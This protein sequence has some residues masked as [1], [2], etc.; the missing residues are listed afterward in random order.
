MRCLL[1]QDS[2]PP[3]V[4][5]AVLMSIRGTP[6]V[7]E[8]LLISGGRWCGLGGQVGMFGL[9]TATMILMAAEAFPYASCCTE[10]LPVLSCLTNPSSNL[11]RWARAV[12]VLGQAGDSRHARPEV[13]PYSR[14]WTF[15]QTVYFSVDCCYC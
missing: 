13:C 4:S 6:P 12:A 1:H 9:I 3:A 14:L 10:T 11:T 2:R 7:W 8:S 5:G 15:A